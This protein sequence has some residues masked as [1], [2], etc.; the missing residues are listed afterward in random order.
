M[1]FH[2]ILATV[3]TLLYCAPANALTKV[4]G[5]R[6]LHDCRETIRSIDVSMTVDSTLTVSLRISCIVKARI[7]ESLDW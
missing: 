1:R 5:G 7:E 3:C 4:N 6:L 2:L